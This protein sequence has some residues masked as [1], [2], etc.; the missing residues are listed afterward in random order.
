MAY[1]SLATEDANLA[2]KLQGVDRLSKQIKVLS[3][4]VGNLDERISSL[5]GFLNSAL[6]KQQEDIKAAWNEIN[7]LNGS[8]AAREKFDMDADVAP[9][10]S[11][12]PVG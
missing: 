12:P 6:F 4:T 5:E 1:E 7:N 2:A 8:N 3:Q 10:P 11:A 9:H